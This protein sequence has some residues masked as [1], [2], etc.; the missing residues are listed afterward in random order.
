MKK[1]YTYFALIFALFAFANVGAQNTFF[2]ETFGDGDGYWK[3]AENTFSRYDNPDAFNVDSITIFMR[4]L[5]P[6]NGYADASGGDYVDMEGHYNWNGTDPKSDTLLF[7]VNTSSMSNVQLH[8]GLFNNT[9]WTGIR[10]HAVT[11]QYSTNA[12]DWTVMDHTTVAQ[13]TFPGSQYWGWVSLAE[14]LPTSKNLHVM[15]INAGDNPHEYFLDDITLSGISNNATLS[16]LQVDGTTI[17]KFSANTTY[18]RYYV[19]DGT[20][21]VPAITAT[22]TDPEATVEVTPAASVPGSTTITVTAADGVTQ[23]VYTVEIRYPVVRGTETI[24]QET[25]GT[26][27]AYWMGAASD[28]TDYT[29]PESWSTDTVLI[30]NSNPSTGYADA[31]GDAALYLGPYYGGSDTVTM[32][33]INT[34]GYKDIHMSFGIYNDTGW[35]GIR[36]HTF[37]AAYSTDGTTWTPMDKN[38]VVAPDTFP[39]NNV[40]AWVTLGED[41]PPAENFEVMFWNPDVNHGWQIDDITLTANMLSSDATLA[42]ITINGAGISG[43][44][45]ATTSY[46]VE[47]P[48]AVIP[49]IDATA[50]DASS[51]FEISLP[52]HVPG[53]A[54]ITVTAEDGSQQVYTLNLIFATSVGK[55]G[56]ITR[57][58]PNPVADVLKINSVNNLNSVEVL[59]VSGKVLMRTDLNGAKDVTLNVSS[60]SNGLYILRMTDTDATTHITRI[61]KR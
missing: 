1:V 22:A 24:M 20:T 35:P 4:N 12:K 32:M 26:G 14:V 5:T 25:F 31:S 57:I 15:F 52:D 44:D 9:G 61:V 39:A 43:F 60:L 36:N 27:S 11:I 45:A 23:W 56:N 59:S 2:Q 40:W 30:R 37:N 48:G 10:Y 3:G 29:G 17:A 33:N 6:S 21:E 55:Y 54:T 53:T 41:L 8:F 16:D 49:T 46:D 50:N 47:C 18:Y 38:F 34:S 51:T 42:N 19:P 13:D 28:Y 58:Y 7:N